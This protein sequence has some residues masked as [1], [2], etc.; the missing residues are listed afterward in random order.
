MIKMSRG[1]ELTKNTLIITIG[2]ISTQFVSF[3][4]LPVYTAL[5]TKEEYGIVDLIMTLV[6]L[7]I[8]VVSLMVDQ[9][10]FRYLL[11]CNTDEEKKIISSA[12][13]ALT[14]TCTVSTFLYG[15]IGIF[16]NNNYM[17]W[18]L[19]ILIATAYSN[20]FLQVSRGLK[21]TTDYA[22]GSFV[23]SASTIIL[24]VICIAALHQGAAGMLIAT[25]IGN[26]VCSLFLFFKL[27]I[28]K[29]V[30]I[31]GF[32]R[33]VSINELRYSIP[34]VPNQLSIWVM[35]S[36]DRLIVTFILG[37]SANGILAVS[38]KFPAI[39][40][41][42]FNIFLLAWHE[43]G[44]I[45]YFDE[46]RDTF[47]TDTLKKILSIFSTLCLGI[48]A[49]LPIAFDW[50]VNSSYEEAYFNIPIY[51]VASLFNVVVGLLGVVYVATKR[52]GEIAKTTMLAAVI[53]IVVHLILIK[54]MGLYA[55]SVSTFVGYGITM[56]YRI[57]DSK[58]YLKIKYD[59]KQFAGIG[60]S[61]IICSFVYYLNN[62][63]I[64]I[65][66]L[67]FFL[68][69]TYF[70]NRDIVENI[71]KIIDR[72]IEGKIN[73]KLFGAIIAVIATVVVSVGGLYVFKKVTSTPKMIQI[74][75]K[76]EINEVGAENIILF[77][78]FNAE[79]FTC[80]GM[81]YDSVDDAFWIGDFGA[82]NPDD[83]AK[84]RVVEVNRSIDTVIREL[85]LSDVLDSSANLQGVAY[86]SNAD[87][88]WLA[89]GDTVSALSKDGEIIGTIQLG[90]YAEY[91]SNGVCYDKNDDSLWVLCA[92]RYL[93]HFSKDGAVLGEYLFN[94]S[95]Q[96][97]ICIDEGYLYITIGADYQG[98]DNYVCKVSTKDGRI[99]AL[100]RVLNANALEGICL[101]DGKMM[102]ANDGFYHFDL[103]GDSYISVFDISDFDVVTACEK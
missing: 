101:I 66:F 39:Y 15:I 34:M 96:D 20:L 2:R 53:N 56:I 13:F 92:S 76:E 83:H 88:L 36:S 94:Y 79:D 70:L 22:L 48:I 75:Y 61:L 91:K 25:F 71:I 74:E 41:T 1:K 78:D 45:H 3:L 4:L 21:R 59:I 14:G 37:V 32:D 35:N 17:I 63:V 81:A 60:V 64:S 62:K 10:A 85:D 31:A 50:F 99:E 52:T 67:P 47:F 5:L 72:K 84:P 11:D 69:A 55:A 80:T 8:P 26:C 7:L 65:I 103:I 86:D 16:V 30:S 46:D 87:C 89:V 82:M 12:F 43:T 73:K 90:K 28:I 42:L 23:C 77:S 19:L 95:D 29:Y 24:N 68:A 51:L 97:H 18:L 38:H 93:L 27:G 49:L 9:G 33:Q 6:Q 57:Y 54:V 44:A 58:K 100:Y 102:I 40:L 98:D